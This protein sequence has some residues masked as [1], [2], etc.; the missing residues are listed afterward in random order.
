MMRWS[1]AA[2][3]VKVNIA[4]ASAT[5]HLTHG[6]GEGWKGFVIIDG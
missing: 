5:L 4:A 6:P 2:G 1:T 3:Q